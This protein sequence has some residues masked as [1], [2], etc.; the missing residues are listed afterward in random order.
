MDS[1]RLPP[2]FFIFTVISHSRPICFIALIREPNSALKDGAALDELSQYF[3]HELIAIKQRVV[4]RAHCD[5]VY[6]Q[7]AAVIGGVRPFSEK[8]QRTCHSIP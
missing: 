3:F 6:Q 7:A 5:Q 8:P 1:A 2:A 4:D